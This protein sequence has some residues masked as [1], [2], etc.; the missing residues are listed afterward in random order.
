MTG[1]VHRWRIEEPSGA[2]SE[3]SC[4]CGERRLFGNSL[5]AASDLSKPGRKNPGRRQ[6][7]LRWWRQG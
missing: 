7:T 6:I 2:V 3:G 4:A 1:H 5:E